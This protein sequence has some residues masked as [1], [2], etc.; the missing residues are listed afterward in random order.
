MKTIYKCSDAK[1]FMSMVDNSLSGT[2]NI[3]EVYIEIQVK[4]KANALFKV[5]VG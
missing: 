1:D 4:S 5:Q 3:I 2:L